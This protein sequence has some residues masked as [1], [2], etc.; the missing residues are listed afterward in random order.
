MISYLIPGII[1]RG[2]KIKLTLPVEYNNS[3]SITVIVV[4]IIITTLFDEVITYPNMA[5]TTYRLTFV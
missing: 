4:I 1:Q 5:P 2:Y 3:Q